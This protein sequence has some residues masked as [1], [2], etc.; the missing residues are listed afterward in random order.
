MLHS[1]SH[2]AVDS[3]LIMVYTLL[4][5]YDV[6]CIME[7]SNGTLFYLKQPHNIRSTSKKF[8]LVLCQLDMLTWCV[9]I[10]LTC[11]TV[12]P[13]PITQSIRCFIGEINKFKRVFLCSQDLFF[14]VRANLVCLQ[15]STFAWDKLGTIKQQNA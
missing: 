11:Q 5:F 4:L 6:M 3:L 1:T 13:Y 10:N 9:F 2:F 14:W 8:I 12:I 7:Y 15:Q